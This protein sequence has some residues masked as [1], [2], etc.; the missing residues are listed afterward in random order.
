MK[1]TT[2]RE[3]FFSGLMT[4]E[5]LEDI[6]ESG[7]EPTDEEL[8]AVY[9]MKDLKTVDIHCS[10]TELYVNLG[11]ISNIINLSKDDKESVENSSNC[12]IINMFPKERKKIKSLFQLIRNKRK[13][14]S[15]WGSK[16]MSRELFVKEFLP[17][18]QNILKQLCEVIEDMRI[19]FDTEFERFSTLVNSVCEGLS[20]EVKALAKSQLDNISKAPALHYN[21]LLETTFSE[22]D[23]DVAED[24][25]EKLRRFLTKAK[26]A[27]VKD[28][29]KNSAILCLKDLSSVIVKYLTKTDGKEEPSDK[30]TSNLRKA[31]KDTLTKSEILAPTQRDFVL[32]VLK[33]MDKA[34]EESMVENQLIYLVTPLAWIER[35]LNKFGEAVDLTDAPKWLTKENLEM[36]L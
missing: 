25:E 1:D 34:I 31:Y 19:G 6:I 5:V 21:I 36:Y 32:L 33:E 17:Y 30:A 35:E 24:E 4:K 7:I 20:P 13:D 10:S 18:Y 11:K 27:Y 29:F 2:S 3:E 9:K 8:S 28:S 12:C 14:L 16:V 26:K 15:A 23:I 22:D